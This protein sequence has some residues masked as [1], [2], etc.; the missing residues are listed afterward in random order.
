[1]NH[2][3]PDT[4][5]RQIGHPV[6]D[7]DGHMLECEPILMDYVRQF[8]GV[9]GLESC[10]KMSER[11]FFR[12]YK[13]S[14]QERQRQRVIRPVWGLDVQNTHDFTTTML[15]GKLHERM[16][17]AVLDFAIVYPTLGFGFARIPDP[18]LRRNICRAINHYSAD[19]FRPYADRLTPAAIIPTQTPA[20]GIEE[21]EY[22]VKTLGLK[23]AVIDAVNIRPLVL[24]EGLDRTLPPE[25]L[26]RLTWLDCYGLDSA[27]DYDPL[28]AKFVELKVA[29]TAHQAGHW[30][31]RTSPSNYVHNHLGL[32]AAAGEAMCKSIFLAGVTHRFP[33]LR[34]GFLE[35]GVGWACSL[36]SDL[37]EHWKK[38]NRTRLARFDP[39]QL[40]RAHLRAEVLKYTQRDVG[41]NLEQE[42]KNLFLVAGG[43]HSAEVELDEWARSGIEKKED[44]R[45]QFVPNFFFGCEG[46][47][48]TASWAF[49]ERVNP[50]RARLGAFYGSDIGHWDVENISEVVSEAY[51][52]VEHGLLPRP[53]FRDFMFANAV[54]LHGGMNPDFFKGTKVEAEARQ[55]LALPGRAG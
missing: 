34:F 44:L 48:R 20:E 38:R 32:F 40:D 19:Q 22:A 25:V 15:P 3:E 52:N 54:R 9:K 39:T 27:H 37:V 16:D 30:G 1:M 42:F 24:A 28:W 4:L 36:F 45:D 23:A 43:A 2:R 7:G 13:L 46:D 31:T 17:E 29:P 49:D 51:E 10:Q 53:D 55:V 35:G 21:L 11:G 5:R 26:A 33:T 6:I 12:W 14:P 18:E 50:F 47:D 41:S 8:A